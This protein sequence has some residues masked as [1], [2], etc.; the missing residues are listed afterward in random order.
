MEF[1]S[2]FTGEIGIISYPTFEM[3]ETLSGHRRTI[4]LWDRTLRPIAGWFIAVEFSNVKPWLFREQT[5]SRFR[6][7]YH[8]RLLFHRQ[9]RVGNFARP[10]S[11]FTYVLHWLVCVVPWY[12][13]LPYFYC[14]G[15]CLNRCAGFWFYRNRISIFSMNVLWSRILF[16]LY[17]CF[18]Q[19]WDM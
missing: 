9:F 7:Y 3:G 1:S 10:Q 15:A 16:L 12:F 5:F 4:D 6:H 18:Y 8:P 2:G 19:W 13:F 11:K 14:W 17:F